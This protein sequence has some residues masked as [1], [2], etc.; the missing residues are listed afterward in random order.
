MNLMIDASLSMKTLIL[1]EGYSIPAS[2]EISRV[3]LMS[4]SSTL[5]L[6]ARNFASSSC[7]PKVSEILRYFHH[8][9]ATSLSCHHLHLPQGCLSQAA[10]MRRD[11]VCHYSPGHHQRA[12]C[13]RLQM[14][15]C[16][17]DE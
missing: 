17:S 10:Q 4:V 9:F 6:K 14:K 1:L 3:V 16:L 12:Y 5:H 13:S 2:I 7:Y 8:Q 15:T 11:F